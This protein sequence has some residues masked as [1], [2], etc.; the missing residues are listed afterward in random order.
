MAEAGLRFWVNHF[1]S[2][3]CGHDDCHIFVAT[4]KCQVKAVRF[5]RSYSE[6]GDLA[7]VVERTQG[8]EAPG[9]GD[10][11]VASVDMD[12][13]VT[14]TVTT[15]TLITTGGIDIL[16]VGNRIS[17]DFTGTPYAGIWMITVEMEQVFT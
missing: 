6:W 16:E 8:T 13:L 12:D 15:G 7:V 1:V 9:S 5:I 11:L 4:M 3:D 17:L 14:D 10:T 2:A